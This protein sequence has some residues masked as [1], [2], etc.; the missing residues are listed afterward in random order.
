MIKRH[1]QDA[2][3]YARQ[4]ALGPLGVWKCTLPSVAGCKLRFHC[5]Q[6]RAGRRAPTPQGGRP[7]RLFER[8]PPAKNFQ[9]RTL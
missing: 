6:R 4:K 5:D 8:F 3:A 2:R 1:E 9:N 7:R